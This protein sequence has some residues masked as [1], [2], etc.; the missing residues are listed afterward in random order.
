[1]ERTTALRVIYLNV[2][3]IFWRWAHRTGH[4]ARPGFNMALSTT[5]LAL[6][7]VPLTRLTLD[8]A[9]PVAVTRGG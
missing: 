7:V 3:L 5:L 6:E 2:I 8:A 9:D 1:M 4:P